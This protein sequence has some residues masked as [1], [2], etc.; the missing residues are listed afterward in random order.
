MMGSVGQATLKKLGKCPRAYRQEIYQRLT[1]GRVYV[2]DPGKK[3]CPR[4][5]SQPTASLAHEYGLR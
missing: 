5:Q 1:T 3:F 4:P 2:L